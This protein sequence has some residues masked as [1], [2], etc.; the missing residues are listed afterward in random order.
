MATKALKK[1]AAFDKAVQTIPNWDIADINYYMDSIG[2]SACMWLMDQKGADDDTTLFH[3]I[4]RRWSKERRKAPGLNFVVIPQNAAMA[5][6]FLAGM[7]TLAEHKLGRKARQF[8]T[9]AA[10]ANAA[11]NCWDEETGQVITLEAEALM[12]LDNLD[13]DAK[14]MF[15]FDEGVDKATAAL[16]AK[17]NS[18]QANEQT[19]GDDESSILTLDGSFMR[20]MIANP[21]PAAEDGDASTAAPLLPANPG[22]RVRK[23]GS[24]G[25]AD[26]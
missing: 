10:K 16:A 12:D 19:A 7:V 6:S 21:A 3:S 8:F 22:P 11:G 18:L 20:G 23:S 2:L 26:K 15:K 24:A 13:A 14:Y 4:N 5:T 17:F 25:A 1:Q 9:E